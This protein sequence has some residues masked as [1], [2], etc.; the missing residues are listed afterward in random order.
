MTKDEAKEVLRTIISPEHWAA[1]TTWME[2]LG[3]EGGCSH[4]GETYADWLAEQGVDDPES[5]GERVYDAMAE[6]SSFGPC[7][8][9]AGQDLLASPHT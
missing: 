1:F 4:D 7:A 9:A 2:E 5:K 3:E 6:Y 8:C